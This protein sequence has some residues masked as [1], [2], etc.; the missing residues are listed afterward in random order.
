M[1]G[2]A[3]SYADRIAHLHPQIRYAERE[4]WIEAIPVAELV[5]RFGSPLMLYSAGIIEDRAR[6]YLAAFAGFPSIHHVA[7]KAN[8]NLTLLH[9][10]AQMGF[11]ADAASLGEL[12]RAEAAGF[13]PEQIVFNGNG[14]GDEELI[15]AHRMGVGRIIVD[16][17]FE[18]APLIET[19]RITG[20]ERV[21]IALRM[22]PDIDAETHPYLATGI[23]ESKFGIPPADLPAVLAA[24]KAEPALELVGLHCHLGSQITDPDPYWQAVD[25]LLER[26]EALRAEGFPLAELTLGGGFAIPYS[27]DESFPIAEYT[28]GLKERLT[29]REL[30]LRQEPGRYLFAEAGL[31]ALTV[32][33]VKRTAAKTFLVGDAG[34]SDNIRPALYHARH[35]VVPVQDT[36]AMETVD[37]VGPLCESGDFLALDIGLPLLARGELLVQ[38]GVG[39]YSYP[40]RMSYNG[41]LQAAEVLVRGNAFEQIRER[42]RPE[43]LSRGDI[44]YPDEGE[45]DDGLHQ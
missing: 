7:L 35:P 26:V 31:L 33:G 45:R 32:R 25:W 42:G 6:R 23:A 36:A 4:L 38:L 19:A 1:P 34:M 18:L 3:D 44:F 16:A 5:K 13:A 9:R 30:L 22:N 2:M 24:I 41:R 10:L 12:H 37:L 14:K 15:R 11:G 8:D 40:M 29:G 27:D 21:P 28:T 43:D 39:A 20:R 17:L